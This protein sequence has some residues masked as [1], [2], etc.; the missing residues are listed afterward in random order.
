MA[1]EAGGLRRFQL[2]AEQRAAFARDGFVGPIPV[3]DHAQ[4]AELGR[5]VDDLMERT[6]ELEP[7]LYE[8]ERA[9]KQRP[10]EVV[11]HCLGGWRVDEWLHDLIWHPAVTVPAA[12]CLETD[13]LRFWH[14]QVFAKP[15]GHPGVVPWH[16][17]YS[18]WQR[19]APAAHITVHIALD[20]ADLDNGCLQYV[21]GSHEWGLF[22]SVDFGGDMDS[23]A[24]R[25]PVELAE[26]F[27]PRPM[28]L[29]AG[30][31]VLHHSHTVHGS[32][33]NGSERPRRALVLNYMADG[34]RS[35]S[36]EPLLRGTT[37]I[38]AG[39]AVGGVFFPLVLDRR[40]PRAS[41][42]LGD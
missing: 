24:R 42:G 40:K 17:D 25:L 16:Q 39:E 7:L 14:D 20:H 29:A 10:E 38:P 18:Y 11:F 1:A 23:F 19:T 37:P 5:R 32:L 21:P 8:V 15:A 3:M 28:R 31:A 41:A 26:A 4:I 27:E 33:G 34:V 13:R 30:E 22:E 36:N 2:T 12:Q 6:H 9:W 35:Q